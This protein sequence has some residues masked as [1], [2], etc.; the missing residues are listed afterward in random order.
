M[1][2]AWPVLPLP[3]F[4]EQSTCVVPIGN[5]E[6]AAGEQLTATDSPRSVAVGGVKEMTFPVGSVVESVTDDAD[7]NEGAVVSTTWM[8]TGVLVGVTPSLNI[9]VHS[10]EVVP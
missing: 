9:A 4:A 7:E 8:T 2:R 5:L 10:P 6:P 1:K 3:S